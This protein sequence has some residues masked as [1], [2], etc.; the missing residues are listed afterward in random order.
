MFPYLDLPGFKRRTIMPASDVDLT[1]QLTPGWTAQAIASRSS[2]LNG[3]F[4]KRYGNTSILPFGQQAPP[5]LPADPTAPAVSLSGRPQLGSAQFQIF[6]TTAGALGTAIFKWSADGGV[7]FTS[8]IATAAIVPLSLGVSANFSAG[9]Y[10]TTHS[11]MAP[12]PV[13]ESVLRWLTTLVTDDSYRKRGRNPQDPAMEDLRADVTRTY[14]EVAECANS[15]TGLFDLPIN[16]DADTAIVTG[17]PLGY[18]EQSPYTWADVQR[19]GA[20]QNDFARTGDSFP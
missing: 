4:R 20:I 2:Y 14:D 12:T 11:W 7:S 3:R 8:G 1:E 15:N 19:D 17:G 9:N 10:L 16:E 13:P 18:S 5:L 6:I